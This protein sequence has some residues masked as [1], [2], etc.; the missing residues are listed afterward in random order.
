LNVDHKDEDR[1]R[2]EHE[3]DPLPNIGDQ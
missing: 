1:K 2:K 3:T